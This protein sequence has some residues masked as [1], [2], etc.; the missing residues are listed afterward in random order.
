MK[1][2]PM[3]STTK[4]IGA[5]ALTVMAVIGAGSAPAAPF[6]PGNIVVLQ[7]GDGSAALGS[8]A[9]PQFVLEYLSSATGQSLPVQTI[10]IPTNG[11]NRL[12]ITGNATSE[13]HIALSLNSS[14][15]TFQGY[16]AALGAP[17]LS[18]SSANG[19][20]RC[21]GQLDFGGNFTRTA[22][23]TSTEFS[24]GSIRSSASDGTNYWMSGSG[25][26]A[27][28]EGIWYSA[29][30]GTPI[31]ITP[32]VNTRV[33]RI[34]NGI[35]YYD[36]STTL[37][38]YA[39]IPT[40][41]ASATATGITG[42]SLYGFSISPAGNVAYVCDDTSTA[43]AI[44][45]WTNNGSTW[46]K[47][48]TFGASNSLTAG[49]RGMAV[50]F[51][52]ANPVIYA[53]TADSATKLIKITDTSVLTAN[54]NV[55]DQATTLAIAPTNTAFRGV[56]L[57]PTSTSTAT[58]PSIIGISP[59]SPTVGIGGTATF[60][61]SGGA[62]YPTATNNWYQITGGTTNLISNQF[63]AL[64][65]GAPTTA[66]AGTY[67]YFG[68]LTNASGSVTSSVVNLT[69]T[70]NA[71][72][73]AITPSGNVTNATG[74]TQTFILTSFPGQPA[75][76]NFW[77]IITSGPAAT[78]QLSDGTQ[79]GA[80][81][82]AVVSGSTTTTLTISNLAT[83]NVSFFA[84]LTNSVPSAATSSVVNLFINDSPVIS[85][86]SPANIT[87]N[88]GGTVT[89]TLTTG[90]ARASNNWYHIIAGAP[91]TTNLVASMT[92]IA[93]ATNATLTLNN[94]GKID[95][96]GYFATLTN[97]SGTA[98]SATVSLT[99]TN[100]PDIIRQPASA[101]GLLDGTVQFSVLAGGTPPSYQ[102]Y[103][104]DAS[105]NILGQVTDGTTTASGQAVVSGSGTST[106]T[107]GNLQYADPTNFVVVVTN[108]YGA[109]TSSV[110]S[111]ISVADSGAILGF[112]NFNAPSNS[113]NNVNP[114]PYFGNGTAS[115][116]SLPPFV[117]T[118]QD[119][120]DGLGLGFPYGLGL[121]NPAN[122]INYNYTWGTSSYPADNATNS[123]LESNKLCGVQFNV[124]TVG[125]KNIAVSYDSRVS[126][127]ASDYERLQYTTNG[128]D[129][130]DYPASSTFGGVSGTGN[131]GFLPFSYSLA[132]FPGVANNPN[133][134]IRI[135]T[136]FQ[137]TATYGLSSNSNYL[138]TANTYGTGGTV[139]YDIVTLTGDAITN[140]NAPPTVSSFANTNMV[141]I[142][143]LTLNYTVGDDTTLPDQLQVSAVSLNTLVNPTF[144]YG[145][146]GAN[147]T[148]G[149]SF[150]DNS[151]VPDPQDNTPI[152]VTVTD[153][154]GDST[155]TWF[156]LAVSSLNQPPTNTL[157]SVTTT[158]TLAN[159]PITI[160]FTVGDD[161][162]PL[163]S[164]AFSASSS[165]Q[166]VVPDSNIIIGNQGTASPSVTIAPAT[167]AV[168]VVTIAVGVTD[169]GYQND[170][171][172]EV[173][174]TTAN[175][176][177]MVRPNT[178]VVF[179]DYFN[180]GSSGALD[181][182]ASGLWNH[183]SGNYHQ[184][185]V[186][187]GYAT[188]DQLDN[189][190]NLQAELVGAPY[191]TNSGA[192]LYASFTVN[193]NSGQMPT[194]F[195]NY[196]ALFNDGSGVT[197]PYECRVVAA[198]NGA[199]PG[200]YRLGI[201][202]FGTNSVDGQMFAQDLS[203]DSNYVVVVSL[204]LATGQSTLWIN[205]TNQ[206]APSVIDMTTS[207]GTNLYNISDFELRESGYS[208]TGNS[209]GSVNLGSLLVGKTFN[210]VIYPPVANPDS[211]AVTENS[212]GNLFTP[213]ANDV[214]G[215]TLTIT[216]VM[217]S[218]LFHG[219]AT[220]DGTNVTYAPPS[221][222]VGTEV[223]A[224]T[225]M[226]NLGNTNSS[227][228]TV[229]VANIPPQANPDSYAVAENSVNN[230]FNPLTNDVVE[231]PGGTLS[232]VSVSPDNHGTA[233][234]S[235]GTKVL[236]TP[237]NGY[238]GMSTIDY[239]V[240]DNIG[241]TNSSTITVTVGNVTPIPV[242]AQLSDGSLILTW[243]NSP[244]AF[245]LQ[246]STNV[247]GPF[248]TIPGATSPYTNLIGTNATGFFRLV[249]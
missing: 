231:T 89:F 96:G 35:L 3:K 143:T 235:S 34:F 109:V 147:R 186:G 41:S 242:S 233:T 54:T 247:I 149:I 73:T 71:I 5:V 114:A 130:I 178:N 40:A 158:N 182:L 1:K 33:A 80:E 212:T 59:S 139:T 81:S 20:N 237:N 44:S 174:T 133:F 13:G 215:G 120:D 245:S 187:S 82:G 7:A 74:G 195:G 154:N 38:A 85:G 19:T 31:Q 115:V 94:V 107:I 196:F 125:A 191:K 236:F 92:K 164:L 162:T 48:F 249:H 184:L 46:V 177:L 51:S 204:V 104:T 121:P 8:S 230:V 151:Y 84:V 197:G 112:W 248:V 131:G 64:T 24:G 135:V 65:I 173:R 113:F 163:G 234:I 172:T 37:S 27:S 9:T 227:T 155:V 21:V 75:A 241:G 210:S 200:Y 157:T 218:G 87:N 238:V 181:T 29:N 198:T 159:T 225:I 199:A 183:L 22:V 160:P 138:G 194:G 6:I 23:G 30:G 43:T 161:Y 140:N 150:G 63:G 146:S 66:T 77:Y 53:T 209:A 52:G 211:Y 148:L 10:A 61:L 118:I 240:T 68:V 16:D 95:A 106:L 119:P 180:Y 192:I 153:T 88:A 229:T 166:A 243:N 205:P 36:S 223:I 176:Q 170:N 244:F 72:I 216:K 99:V 156:N 50:D 141:D 98:T 185:Q 202:N 105:G 246:S 169:E 188:V 201:N 86:I 224:Y 57:A 60:T 39:G 190:E 83:T 26:P 179:A 167:N 126:P 55:T 110:A 111:L 15:L 58:A 214:S 221:G 97:L 70:P 219:T 90:I 102:W 124:S 145:G 213:L 62:G 25:S 11:S 220:T 175:M 239:Q 228:I 142:D 69:V 28:G 193:M 93:G 17:S 203:P 56:A 32:S 168:G 101:F 208:G 49:C 123:V 152:E 226:D 18:S 79:I 129:W 217:L 222:F 128:T 137:S 144:T 132:G 122:G 4:N 117:T 165:Y 67:T 47:A 42:S 91:P 116:V 232:L 206:S 136:E 45:K 2:K 12:L 78:N 100:D 108:V 76:S 14:N 127:T 103:F 134:G 171:A 189:A 207:A